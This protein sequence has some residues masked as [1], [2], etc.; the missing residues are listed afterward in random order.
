MHPYNSSLIK[1][2]I[3]V[4]L[5]S[6]G[7]LSFAP[8]S[9]NKCNR[10]IVPYSPIRSN[11]PSSSLSQLASLKPPDI[12]ELE[13]TNRIN[14]NIS[15]ASNENE[16]ETTLRGEH[17]SSGWQTT[18][19]EK[20]FLGIDPTPEVLSIMAIYFVEGAL[21]LARLAQTFF[22]KDE[23]HLGPAELS[24]L[25]G[26]FTLPWTI[27]VSW[28]LDSFIVSFVHSNILQSDLQ[29]PAHEINFTTSHSMDF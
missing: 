10:R 22:L 19:K 13:S 29:M 11:A 24:A 16:K 26:L 12:E 18:L 20:A 8:S 21:G 9:S 27:K 1:A 25:T 3:F 14:V 17:D 7:S 2:V 15:D 6:R 28:M 5:Q 23:L 4:L